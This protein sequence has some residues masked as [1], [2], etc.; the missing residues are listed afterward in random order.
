MEIAHNYPTTIWSGSK[1]NSSTV[2]ERIQGRVR[3]FKQSRFENPE[4]RAKIR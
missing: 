3:N 4:S 2:F 1:E